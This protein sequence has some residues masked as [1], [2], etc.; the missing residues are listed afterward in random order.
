[1][2]ILIGLFGGLGLFL[3][4][5]QIASEGL[6]LAAGRRLKIVLEVLT[7][8]RF[9][10]VLLGIVITVLIQSSSATTVILVGLVN[11]SLMD[12]AQ[13][14]G[15]TLGSNVGTTL[16]VQLIAFK[17]SD[18][19]LLMIG[20]AVIIILVSSKNKR[21]KYSGQVLLGFGLVFFEI[22]RAHV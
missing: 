20:A 21:L 3:Y 22:G 14:I 18:Y 2:F 17:V 11:A 13:T 12:L 6:Q 19:A 4:G 15:V 7:K 9:V 5:M 8:N 1:M 10:A 16:T